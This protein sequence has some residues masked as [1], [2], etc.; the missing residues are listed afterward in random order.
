MPEALL[1]LEGVTLLSPE[2]LPVF[3]GLDWRL[4]RGARCHLQGGQGNGASAFLRLCCGIARPE[5]GQ[6]LLEGTALA[7]A[8]GRHPFLDRGALGYVPSDGGL[9]VNL[10]LLDNVA[11]PLRFALNQGRAEA[12]ACALHWLEEAGLQALAGQ[13]PHVPGDGQSWLASLARAAA[14]RPQLWLVDRPAGGLD[15]RSLRAAHG[16]LE[17]AAQDP[18]VTLVLVGD[19]WMGALGRPLTLTDGRMGSES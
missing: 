6:V 7:S 13:R 4:E 2:G 12:Q 8:T 9:A 10:S 18:G 16:L 3:Q 17:G 14:R 15:A 19:D 1:A 5:A 11:L